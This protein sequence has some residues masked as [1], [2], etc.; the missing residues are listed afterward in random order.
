[1][2]KTITLTFVTEK[3]TCSDFQCND[4]ALWRVADVAERAVGNY[5]D[6]HALLH[7]ELI[8]TDVEHR[9]KKATA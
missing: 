6:R 7:T 5:C 8:M 2:P 4:A 1:M 9:E 3:Q